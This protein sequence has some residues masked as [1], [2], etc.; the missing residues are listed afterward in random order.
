MNMI[1]P[2]SKFVPWWMV[3]L[4]AAFYCYEYLLR[5]IPS[6]MVPELMHTFDIQAAKIGL[7]SSAYYIGYVMSS[8]IVGPILDRYLPRKVILT[9]TLFCV[10]GCYLFAM[11]PNFLT[12]S[13]ARFIIGFASA[14]GFIGVLK[15]GAMWLPKE[16]FGAVAGMASFLGMMTAMSGQ[17]GLCAMMDSMPWQDL[18]SKAGLVGLVLLIAIVLFLKDRPEHQSNITH[19]QP[20]KWSSFLKSKFF[21][22]N[23][24]IGCTTYLPLIAFADLW[25]VSFVEHTFSISRTD[26]AFYNSM[27]YLGWAFGAPFFGMMYDATQKWGPV[28]ISGT[29]AALASIVWVVYFPPHA[30]MIGVLL[31][32]FGFFGS[33]HVLVFISCRYL[34]PGKDGTALALTNFFIMIGGMTFQP[35]IGFALDTLSRYANLSE[36][37]QYGF[38]LSVI[39]IGFFATLLL[40]VPLHREIKRLQNKPE[41]MPRPQRRIPIKL[42]A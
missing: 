24:I 8:G 10:I 42:N 2:I 41:D 39:P 15:I 29:I 6:V 1:K 37:A 33:S 27:V 4:G 12:A 23:G 36:S 7:L 9:A 30:S 31:F 26:A 38:A 34:M 13:M 20:Q 3:F 21:W 40:I 5:L 11:A 18:S 28:L 22:I 14:F 25:G 16:R 19:E 17:N 35:F 32:L